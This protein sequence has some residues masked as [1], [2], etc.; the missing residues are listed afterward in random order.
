MEKQMF[1]NLSFVKVN[2][3]FEGIV[4]STY[5]SEFGGADKKNT[6]TIYKLENGVIVDEISWFDKDEIVFIKKD[7]RLARRLV[8]KFE[9]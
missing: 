4:K 9:D 1:E 3:S 5:Y 6:Y 8:K 7:V 2:N